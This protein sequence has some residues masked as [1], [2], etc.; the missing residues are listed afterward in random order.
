MTGQVKEEVITRFGE[1]G[2]HVEDGRV[3][4]NPAQLGEDDLSEGALKFTLCGT[5]IEFVRGQTGVRLHAAD[6][7]VTE[8][9]GRRLDRQASAD[10]L[11]RS[12]HW[13]RVQVGLD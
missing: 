8:L 12:G 13:H 2:V 7:S 5:P 9:E 4:F 6:G 11:S 10:L 3:H 1:L